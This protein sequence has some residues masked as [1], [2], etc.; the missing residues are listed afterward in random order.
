MTGGAPGEGSASRAL[1][2]LANP[3][4]ELAGRTLANHL[5]LICQAKGFANVRFRLTTR[6]C[7]FRATLPPLSSFPTHQ[8]GNVIL[9]FASSSTTRP[10]GW[11]RSRHTLLP[12]FSGRNPRRPFA[13]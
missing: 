4:G 2:G 9:I 13:R 11:L 8:A 3:G 5:G 12:W 7:D 10:Q 1:S 6:H